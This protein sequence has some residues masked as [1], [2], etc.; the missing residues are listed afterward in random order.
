VKLAMGWPEAERR[1]MDSPPLSSWPE[2]SPRMGQRV[3]KRADHARAL[4]TMTVLAFG[5]RRFWRLGEAEKEM[6]AVKVR[7]V[8]SMG[9]LEELVRRMNSKSFSERKPA[10]VSEAE[11]GAGW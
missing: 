2:N 1:E 11:G 7:P 9:E 10:A 5:G 4:R 3:P 8:R 6:P